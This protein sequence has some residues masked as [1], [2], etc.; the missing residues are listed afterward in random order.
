[1]IWIFILLFI[2]VL[3]VGGYFLFQ[4]KEAPTVRGDTIVITES[5]TKFETYIEMPLLQHCR[6]GTNN[7]SYCDTIDQNTE[8]N[9]VYDPIGGNLNA[10]GA[11][12]TTFNDDTNLCSDGTRNCVYQEKFD[13]ERKLIGITNEM[14]ENLIEKFS[15]DLWSGKINLNREIN[16]PLNGKYMMMKDM[17][18]EFVEFDK[19]TGK[20]FINSGD[21]KFEVIPGSYYETRDPTKTGKLESP[22]GIIILYILFYYYGNNLPKPTIKLNLKSE[23]TLGE[24]HAEFVK[25]RKNV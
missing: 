6:E 19:N 14:G 20:L 11:F 4:R 12:T 15:D 5:G 18:K 21:T 10:G 22:V 23:K 24:L 7:P 9:Y 16:N 1:M 13:D 2:M 8:M 17:F 25:A 3:V